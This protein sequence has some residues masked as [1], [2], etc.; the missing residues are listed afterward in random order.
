[1]RAERHS[2]GDRSENPAAPSSLTLP[3]AATKNYFSPLNCENIGREGKFHNRIAR[4]ATVADGRVAEVPARIVCA[5]SAVRV[6]RISLV[7]CCSTG[8]ERGSPKR[9]TAKVCER[10]LRT[11]TARRRL[12]L[13]ASA[14]IGGKGWRKALNAFHPQLPLGRCTLIS[15]QLPHRLTKKRCYFSFLP[16]FR[17][18]EF[19]CP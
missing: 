17:L 6:H 3:R 5:S 14:R 15:A 10:P 7:A 11:F 9:S 12:R 13:N 16:S 4:A 1:V 8:K 18:L 19:E 2:E